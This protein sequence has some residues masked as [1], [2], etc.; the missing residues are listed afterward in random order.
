MKTAAFYSDA[1]FYNHLQNIL[2]F[3]LKNIQVWPVTIT[4]F[5]EIP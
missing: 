4:F 5:E 2:D 3:C 1:I